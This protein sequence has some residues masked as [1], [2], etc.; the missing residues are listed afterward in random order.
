MRIT[1]IF[2]SLQGE[3]LLTGTDSVFVR[4]S[5]CNLRCR[6]CDTPYASWAPEGEEM[7]LE[8]IIERMNELAAERRIWPQRERFHPASHALRGPHF[9]NLSA[10]KSEKYVSLETQAS[11]APIRHAV[12]TGGEPMLFEGLIALTQTL[13][14]AGWHITIETSGTLY[15]PV[16]CDLMSISPKLSNSSPDES[17]DPRQRMRHELNRSAPHIVQRLL[18]EYECQFKFVVGDESDCREAEEYAAA[19]PLLDRRRLMLMPQG[20]DAKTL[21]EHEKWLRPYCESHGLTYCPRKHV[22]WFGSRRGV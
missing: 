12:I 18:T 6:Y 4:L 16:A 13:R 20:T 1:E 15:L 14:E 9:A 22:E 8:E 17:C 11:A 7:S 5:G 10:A 19:L 3:G 2:R 21:S